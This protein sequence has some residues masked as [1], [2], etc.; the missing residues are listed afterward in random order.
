M[1]SFA[2]LTKTKVPIYKIL[3]YMDKKGFYF[4]C[5]EGI[6]EQGYENKPLI[7]ADWNPP[8]MERIYN[9]I[10]KYYEG[11]FDLDWSDE[12]MACDKCGRAVR[13]IHNSYGWEPSYLSR[14][15]EVL[16]IECVK[17]TGEEALENYIN[18]SS[19]ALPSWAIEI[20]E[21]AGFKCFEDEEYCKVYETGL[22]SYQTDDPK[23]IEKHIKENLPKHDYLFAINSTGQFD[24]HWSVFVKKIKEEVKQA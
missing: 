7:C 2:E 21:E 6:A 9:W 5:Y 13:S 14:D 23:E 16:C 4:D 8:E 11:R 3:D 17:D 22:H 1:K 10:E 18:N 12:W 24:V 15:C 20:A 19:K